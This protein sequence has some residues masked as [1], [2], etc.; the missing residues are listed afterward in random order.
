[1]NDTFSREGRAVH[2][3]TRR[4]SPDAIEVRGARVRDLEDVDVSPDQIARSK[5]GVAGR[6]LRPLV[7][8]E[9]S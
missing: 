5:T 7:D 1:V 3:D 9:D 2:H 6:Y 4:Q 8:R